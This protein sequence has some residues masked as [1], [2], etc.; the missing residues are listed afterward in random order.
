MTTSR[1]VV[2]YRDVLAVGEFRALW[3]A[4]MQSA[5]GDQFARVALSILVFARTDSAALT[6]LAYALTFLPT[7]VGGVLL[8]GLADRFPRRDL[9]V[10]LDLARAALMA[11]MTVPGLPL[12]ALFAVLIGAAIATAPFSA[13]VGALLPDVLPDDDQYVMGAALRSLSTQ[14]AQVLGF[15]VGGVVVAVIGARAALLVDAATFVASAVVIRRWVGWRPSVRRRYRPGT[16][17]HSD[18]IFHTMRVIART[19][20]LRTLVAL[21]ALSGLLVVP[22]GLA[23][24]YAADHGAGPVAVGVLLTGLPAGTAVGAALIARLLPAERRMG[25]LGVMAALAGLPLV[26]MFMHPSIPVTV[27][28]LLLVGAGGSYQV[29]ASTAFVRTVAVDSRGAALGFAGSVVVASQGLGVLAF[30]AIADLT[31]A[32][33]AAGIA[34]VAA[35]GVGLLLATALRG[36]TRHRPV[37][38]A[39]TAAGDAGSA[40][41]TAS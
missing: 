11:A 28:L 3:A 19:P 24:P 7:L 35:T 29:L 10:A 34:G 31:G 22:E 37:G 40:V 5:V 38:A 32:A 33:R 23:A 13:A 8:S 26:L 39:A 15:A 41:P 4:L 2:R 27:A 30:A 14:L 21:G 36:V 12:W 16:E 9:L 25:A 20:L 6:G 18:S 17:Q 1:R